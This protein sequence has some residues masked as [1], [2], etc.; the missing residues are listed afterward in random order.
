[1][2]TYNVLTLFPG[3]FSS[4]CESSIWQRAIQSKKASIKTIDIRD[5]TE[6]KH[7]RADDYP[8]GGGS[9]MVLTPEPVHRC[10]QDVVSSCQRPYLNIYM[11]PGG[12]PLTHQR[13]LDL[14]PYKCL[15]I[16]CGHYEGVD[17]RVISR[18]ID[19]EISVGDFVLTGGELAAMVLIDACIRHVDGVLGNSE[20]VDAESFSNALL[21]YPQ[22]TRPAVFE[23]EAVPAVLLSGHHENVADYRR[24]ASLVETAKKR[25]DLLSKTI[26]S[27][28][29]IDL[30]TDK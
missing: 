7:R 22:Y 3:M 2:M 30:I 20:S 29:D 25:P 26:L 12:K 8:F 11:S 4:I 5:Y 17:A 13:V 23:G 28:D 6:D 24:R 16:L 1:M 27:K 10:F 18:H 21:E 14:A 19:M 15:N 9:G